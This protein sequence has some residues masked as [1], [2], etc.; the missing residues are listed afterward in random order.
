VDD[1]RTRWNA[2]VIGLRREAG[3]AGEPAR[4]SWRVGA[5]RRLRSGLTSEPL[6][7]T[8]RAAVAAVSVGGTAESETGTASAAGTGAYCARCC[9]AAAPAAPAA[10]QGRGEFD[11]MTVGANDDSGALSAR[12]LA[13]VREIDLGLDGGH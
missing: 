12:A 7:R 11:A 13:E 10:G 6:S 2:S 8:A 4:R 3:E 9:A 5:A 1:G